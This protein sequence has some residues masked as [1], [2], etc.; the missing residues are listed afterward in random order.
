MFSAMYW[1]ALYLSWYNNVSN[2]MSLAHNRQPWEI[3]MSTNNKDDIGA[4]TSDVNNNNSLS[5]TVFMFKHN[6][7][8]NNDSENKLS[9]RAYAT[10]KVKWLGE[11]SVY[12][13]HCT[14][15]TLEIEHVVPSL[16]V[17][18]LLQC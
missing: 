18:P 17:G 7:T 12:H 5:S 16:E 4:P 14:V 2:E 15:Y 1:N 8:W 11:F 3:V 13:A 9:A 10:Q 6:K